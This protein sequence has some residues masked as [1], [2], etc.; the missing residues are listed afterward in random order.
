MTIIIFLSVTPCNL[1]LAQAVL[2]AKLRKKSYNSKKQRMTRNGC[3]RRTC[4]VSN[5]RRVEDNQVRRGNHA[6][7]VVILGFRLQVSEHAGVGEAGGGR[8]NGPS[9]ESHGAGAFQEAVQLVGDEV[10]GRG[11]EVGPD[12]ALVF[13]KQHLEK[14]RGGG[15]RL[16]MGVQ[17]R[18]F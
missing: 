2:G 4:L 1:P 17:E 15:W 7:E 6:V 9:E 5:Q 14:G 18:I 13:V 16:E 10:I 8:G 12:R 11:T 3:S